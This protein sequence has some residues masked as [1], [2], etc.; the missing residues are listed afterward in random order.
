MVEIRIA[1]DKSIGKKRYRRKIMAAHQENPKREKIETKNERT[2]KG[3]T[4]QIIF[5]QLEMNKS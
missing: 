2:E 3:K 1:D 4:N 5:K